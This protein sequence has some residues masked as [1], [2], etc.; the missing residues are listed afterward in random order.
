MTRFSITTATLAL[1]F[2]LTGCKDGGG[3]FHVVGQI[4]EAQDTMLYLEHLGMDGV[5]VRVDSV[6][7]KEKGDFDLK[8][9]P[10]GN[11]EFY[12]LRVGQQ[13]INLSVDS[14]ETITIKAALP[15]MATDYTVEGSGNCDTIRMLTNELRLLTQGMQ[16]VA[17]DRTL[18]IADREA[19]IRQM[20]KDY[21]TRVKLTY[22]QNR[23][24]KASSYFAMFQMYNGSMV[25]DPVTDA[26]DVTWF[27]AI[28]NAW[29]AH[30]PES[31]RTKNLTNIALRGHRNTRKKVLE[32]NLDDEKVSETGIIDMTFPDNKGVERTLS[33]LKGNVVLL[34]FTAYAL[35]G[36]SE[37]TMALREL[38]SKYHKRGLEIYQVSLDA[39]EH[40]WKTMCR[41]LPW[42][43]VWDRNGTDNDIVRIYSLQQVPTWF[44]IDRDMNLVGRQEFMGA[45]EDEIL[46]L[47]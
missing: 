12:R 2:A 29:D 45:L 39:D 14:T 26:S 16:S 38:Y 1:A 7:L 23:Y 33:Q 37:R 8:G 10:M 15:T 13:I 40:Y 21:K 20:I 11:P 5:P 28:A 17:N 47:L 18:T 3:K 42:V 32:V 44:L 36:S 24:D 4:S 9:E 35:K 43:C 46:K 22:V 27:S 25:F 34:D 30:W 6:K 19:T 31:P 41:N